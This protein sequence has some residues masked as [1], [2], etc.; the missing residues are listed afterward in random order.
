V[1]VVEILWNLP[2][3]DEHVPMCKNVAFLVDVL[4]GRAL[5]SKSDHSRL[6]S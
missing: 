5:G 4:A 6:E 2:K 3:K 1:V